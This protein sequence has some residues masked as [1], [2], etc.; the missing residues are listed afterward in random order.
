MDD[1]HDTPMTAG[2]F[3]YGHP[4]WRLRP[5][6]TDVTES[7]ENLTPKKF[8]W[9][10]RIRSREKGGAELTVTPVNPS[11]SHVSTSQ[12]PVIGLSGDAAIREEAVHLPTPGA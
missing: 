7:R 6:M 5:A 8:A 2:P 9:G 11:Q 3:G 4:L 10:P 1:R 12:A